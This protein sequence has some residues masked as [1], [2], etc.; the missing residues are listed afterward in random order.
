[1]TIAER[2]AT[3][4]AAAL[5]S[6]VATGDSDPNRVDTPHPAYARMRERYTLCRAAAAGTQ[7]WQALD[8]KVLPQME[9]ESDENYEVRKQIAALHPGF[10]KAVDVGVGLLLENE[11][12]PDKDASGDLLAFWDD[13]TGDGTHAALFFDDLVTAAMID[14][15]SGIFTDYTRSTDPTLD[16]SK[17]SAAAV[18][19]AAL[20]AADTQAL[21]LRAYWVLVKADEIIKPV[22]QTI[23]GVKTLVLFVRKEVVEELV[24][25]YGIRTV[26]KYRAY[27]LVGEKVCCQVWTQRDGQQEPV[28]DGERVLIQNQTSIPWS[29][30]RGGPR[31][32][33]NETRPPL[34]SLLYLVL[35]YHQILTNSLSL[36]SLACVPSIVR[37]GAQMDQ[38]TKK[39]PPIR[40]GPRETIEA[41]H[42]QGVPEPVYWLS[43][44]VTVLQPAEESLTR[45]ETLMGVASGSFLAPDK[46]AAET[47]K[48]KQMANRAGN[49]TLGGIGR[50]LQDT[51]ELAMLHV[52]RF[53]RGAA[54]TGC[55]VT[56]NLDFEDAMMDANVMVAYCKLVEAGYPKKLALEALQMGGRIKP[57]ADLEE[58]EAEWERE[59]VARDAAKQ[60]DAQLTAERAKSAEQTP[61][62]A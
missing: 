62:A 24:E 25:P 9:G 61:A 43:P 17:A 29:P 58:L 56:V 4:A 26:T 36:Q 57:D 54:A 41:P 5:V 60:L 7:A 52:D 22:Y 49:A 27:Q 40:L 2:A 13:V 51:I 10:E 16:R 37:I 50:R 33:Q 15:E 59:L 12:V 6:T 32:G 48:S 21:G 14:G 3:D 38:T 47:E 28:K 8:R 20:D 1:M 31:V 34:M 55:S 53:Q 44:D 46:R 11:P 30:L 45:T 35:Q 19:G 18:P 42:V 23:G 39:Y